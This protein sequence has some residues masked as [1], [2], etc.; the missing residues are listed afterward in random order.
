MSDNK[1]DQPSKGPERTPADASGTKR[2]YATIDLK[3]T[4]VSENKAA[5]PADTKDV[6]A[7]TAAKVAAADA[8]V[9]GGAGAGATGPKVSEPPKTSGAAAT[10]AGAAKAGEAASK[11]GASAVPPPAA[12]EGSGFGRFVSHMAAGILGGGLAV[13]AAPQLQPLLGVAP[14]KPAEVAPRTA[15]QDVA[16]IAALEKQMQE[17][18]AAANAQAKAPQTSDE[19]KTALSRIDN[20]NTQIAG[21]KDAQSKLAAENEA[22]KTTSAK[23]GPD[24]EAMRRIAKLEEQL[25]SMASAAAAD[26]LKA[27]RLPQLAQLTGQVADLRTALENRL[28]AQRKDLTQEIDTRITASAE[29]AEAARAGTQRIDREVAA[30]RAEANRMAA[31]LD[32]LKTAA[33]QL[34][35]GLKAVRED[36]ASTKTAL[37]AARTELAAQVKAAAKPADVAAAVTPVAQRIAKLETSVDG[38][39]KAEADRKSNAERIVL[40]LELGNLKRT[41]ER[42]LPYEK[43]LAEVRKVAGS[44]IDLAPLAR[45]QATG[46][47]TLSDLAESFRPIANAILDAEAEQ[48]DATVLDRLMSGAKTLVRVRK[49]SHEAGDTSTEAM[50]SRMETAVKDGRLALV[51]S[52]AKKLPA[53][54][55]APAKDWLA[56]VEARNAVDVALTTIDAALKSS[57]GA[58]PANGGQKG[59]K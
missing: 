18:I 42:G 51:L 1:K 16:R 54:A 37:D 9:K 30:L 23:G 49:T 7:E 22:L 13:V 19:I 5:K 21:L 4:V 26:P 25:T 57:L 35:I 33:D 46:V 17:R 48:G 24:E 14:P 3:A 27:G 50:L 59:T 58:G 15:P 44:R 38:V 53:K 47:P 55:Q 31:R 20:L 8:A 45:Y 2:P 10:A 39:L 36:A 40:S 11:G 29:A 32:Q 12:R 56:K 52:E 34:E 28:A 43:E 41:L 6:N